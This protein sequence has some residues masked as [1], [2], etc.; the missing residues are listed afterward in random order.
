MVS[1][2]SSVV[3]NLLGKKSA[4]TLRADT[5]ALAT[6]VA[7]AYADL[8]VMNGIIAFI[9]VVVGVGVLAMVIGDGVGGSCAGGSGVGGS[10]V[11]VKAGAKGVVML[12][13]FLLSWISNAN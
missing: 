7:R 13:D 12:A 9:F 4:K 6:D 8:L 5:P 3:R 1:W 2:S 11:V 10:G